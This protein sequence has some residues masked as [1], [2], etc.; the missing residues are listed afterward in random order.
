VGGGIG[1]LGGKDVHQVKKV[2]SG[3]VTEERGKI[4]AKVFTER[5]SGRI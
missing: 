3:K 1:S 2:V 5:Q 4:R